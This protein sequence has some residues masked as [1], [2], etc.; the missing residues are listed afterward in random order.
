MNNGATCTA[1]RGG[2]QFGPPILLDE[3]RED[4]RQRNPVQR[5]SKMGNTHDRMANDIGLM[6]E[7]DRLIA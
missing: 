3:F 5:I 6:T 2:S 7:E 1:G 4:G